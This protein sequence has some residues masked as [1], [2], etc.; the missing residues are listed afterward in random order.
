MNERLKFQGRLAEKEMESKQLALRIRGLVNA[1]RDRMDPF[2]PIEDLQ[3][4]VA[5]GMA[6]ELSEAHIRYKQLQSEIT[7]IKKALGK[8]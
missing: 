2:E 7:A 6:V 3:T 8:A 1:I 4:D 5:A